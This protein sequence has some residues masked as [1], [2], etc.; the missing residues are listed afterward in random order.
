VPAAPLVSIVINNYNYG[1]F[2]AE[3][4]DSAL[5]QNYDNIEIIV[6][7][8]GSTDN[9][10]DVISGYG[11]RVTSVLKA[12]GGQASAFNAGFARSRG[13]VI[14]FLDSDDVLVPDIVERVVLLF[15]RHP[16]VAIVSFRLEFVTGE[17]ERTG[18]L[19]PPAHLRMPTGNQ[20][21]VLLRSPNH[22]G[23]PPTSGNAFTR[24]HLVRILPM[25]EAP[26]RICA[27][28][29]LCRAAALS[30]PALAI[31]RVGGLYRRH[32]SNNFVSPGV[33]SR[34]F[35]ERLLLFWRSHPYL[36]RFARSIGVDGYPPTVAQAQDVMACVSRM[37]SLRLDPGLHPLAR[38]RP[39][40]VA[41]RG[42]GAS[43]RSPDPDKVTRGLHVLWFMAMAVAPRG[44][45]VRLSEY[46]LMPERRRRL[47]R[48]LERLR[49]ESVGARRGPR[50][51]PERADRQGVG[52]GRWV[53]APVAGP[54][55][56]LRGLPR[57][58]R[59]PH[60]PRR[61]VAN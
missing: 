23:G 25:P 26:F 10:R 12:N 43:Y 46:L 22:W 34:D 19:I 31:D 7:D 35:R 29:Y 14:L 39:L 58:P 59:R 36:L 17:G 37:I 18:V 49:T 6:V 2:L 1:R 38:D 53:D 24:R 48:V 20:R 54:L 11:T 28:Y 56:R 33:N 40:R 60:P 30:G 27:D 44:A 52:G 21:P 4:I 5:S 41:W 50:R 45:A 9:S 15:N 32:G 13:D 16:E 42:I 61:R 55:H 8:D 51:L 47:N 57:P 3:A